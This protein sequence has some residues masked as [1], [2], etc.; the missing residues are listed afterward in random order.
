MSLVHETCVITGATSGIGRATAVQ[1]Q[2]KGAR[3]ILIERNVRRG[4]S[5]ARAL[6]RKDQPVRFAQADLGSR[7][8]VIAL[9][10]QVKA[11]CESV[12][13]LVNNAGARFD[14]Y[15]QTV[16]GMER[17]FAVNH[18]GHFLL[19]L[20]LLDRLT[21]NARILVVASGAH[22]VTP[23]TGWMS[24]KEQYDRRVA[25]GSSKLANILFAYELSR[26]LTTTGVTVNAIDPGGV[27]TR[28]GR[29]NGL[30]A[31]AKHYLY[32]LS[33]HQLVTAS[34]AARDIVSLA[35]GSEYGERTGGYFF[36]GREVRSSQLSYDVNE[37]RRLWDLSYTLSRASEL[38]VN[39]LDTR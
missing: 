12:D 16:D 19:T 30:I 15:E 31:S 37:A 18:L 14:T 21:S 3:L 33:R 10:E 8:D 7:R 22:H 39:G 32:Y 5:L 34:T 1:M 4:E 9:S 17:T 36:K 25:Y 13:V 29:N 20:L 35:S 38:A 24:T 23:P 27:A 11:E 28:L 6:R 2:A 26:R